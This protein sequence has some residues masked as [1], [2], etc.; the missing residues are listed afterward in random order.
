MSF[1]DPF[2]QL[3]QAPALKQLLAELPPEVRVPFETQI[4][5]C[6]AQGQ[7]AAAA[8]KALSRCEACGSR[9]YRSASLP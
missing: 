8:D 4:G 9:S 3:P 5:S 6:I 1:I 7:E 2:Y